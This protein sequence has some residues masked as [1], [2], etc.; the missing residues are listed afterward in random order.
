MMSERGTLKKRIPSAEAD[1][2]RAT[3][4]QTFPRPTLLIF[5][6]VFLPDPASVG[7]HIADVAAEMARRGHRVILFAANRSYEDASVRYPAREIID[8]VEVHRLPFSSFGKKS[9]LRRILG[10]ALFLIQCLFR[11][12]FLPNLQGVFFSTSPPLIGVAG[13]IIGLI[14]RVPV[15]YWAMDLNPD[16]LIALGKISDQGFIAG[17]LER[18]NRFILRRARLTIALDRFMADRLRKR[19]NLDGRLAVIP[20]WPHEQHI[21]SVDQ[22]SNP[23][24]LKLNLAGKF[25]F[26]YSGNHSSSN[27]LTTLLTAALHFKDDPTV[28]FLF[29]GGGLGKLEIETLI[30]EHHLANVLSLPYQ[31]LADLKY[32]LSAADVHIVALGDAMVGIIHPCKIYGAMAASRPILFLGPA[33]S[34]VSDLLERY[35]IG[36]HI[37]HAPSA[38]DTAAP[39]DAIAAIEAIRATPRQELDAMGARAQAALR[40]SLS[41]SLLCGQFCD[42]VEAALAGRPI[43]GG[44]KPSFSASR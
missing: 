9:T 12:L 31:P 6:Q 30:R 7:Q 1:P 37:A 26:M 33:P 28:C 39:S 29:V 27:P 36:W 24:R 20:P 23:F 10:T 43:A 18:V 41:Q 16:Q 38:A 19:V 15:V 4:T 40:A 2:T 21:E 22:S 5:S 17:V 25:I 8:A 13:S 42:Q 11:G 34:H 14:R 32:S 3:S 44:V 35:H